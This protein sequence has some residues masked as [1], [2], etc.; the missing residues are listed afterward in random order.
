MNIAKDRLELPPEAGPARDFIEVL[1]AC[2]KS[3]IEELT[4]QVQSLWIGLNIGTPDEI[5]HCFSTFYLF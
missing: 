4:L 5:F 1:V 2:Y 3:Q